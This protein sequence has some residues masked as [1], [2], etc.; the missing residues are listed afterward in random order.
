[1]TGRRKA[2]VNSTNG[3]KFGVDYDQKSRMLQKRI[4]RYLRPRDVQ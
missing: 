1:M 2:K 4:L 3:T